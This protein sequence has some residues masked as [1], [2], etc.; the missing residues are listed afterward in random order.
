MLTKYMLNTL[1]VPAVQGDPFGIRANFDETVTRKSLDIS[2]GS[3]GE[4][5]RRYAIKRRVV[6]C[7]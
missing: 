1:G 3:R 4:T 7:I 5:P 2:A 6:N